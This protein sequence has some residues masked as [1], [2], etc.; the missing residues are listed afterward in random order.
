MWSELD[1]KTNI[2]AKKFQ[3]A[4]HLDKTRTVCERYLN[5]DIDIQTLTQAVTK[6][7]R[8]IARV[9]REIDLLE[10]ILEVD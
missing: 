7:E 3:V 5:K 1:I 8:E 6:S 9:R 2:T 4:E 10:T